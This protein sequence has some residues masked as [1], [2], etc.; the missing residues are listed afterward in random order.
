MKNLVA[1]L[2]GPLNRAP[3]RMLGA[4]P[5]RIGALELRLDTLGDRVLAALSHTVALVRSCRVFHGRPRLIFTWRSPAEG[6]ASLPPAGRVTVMDRLLPGL[7]RRG[8][9]LDVEYRAG[10]CERMLSLARRLGVHPVLSCH[11]L[12]AG[13]R[14][15]AGAERIAPSLIEA[16]RRHAGYAKL[17]VREDREERITALIAAVSR[18][19][20]KPRR[21]TV[22]STGET[23][24][25]SRVAAILLGMPLVY[26]G[27]Q[28]PV[29]PSQPTIASLCQALENA[30][31][32]EKCGKT[33]AHRHSCPASGNDIRTAAA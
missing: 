5:C 25:V 1:V 10:D 3:E 16:A 6:G 23:A 17:V 14:E 7:V 29:L 4:I 30:G 11:F 32:R 13:G 12:G 9:L 22:F 19:D 2:S 28:R 15:C 21:A 31:L 18:T 24:L 33:A 26:A 27:L 20:H 8:D